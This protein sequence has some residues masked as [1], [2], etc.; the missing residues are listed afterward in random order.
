PNSSTVK[1]VIENAECWKALAYSG[2]NV[3]SS[4]D[5]LRCS[6]W[7]ELKQNNRVTRKG[8]NLS[9]Q[10]GSRK[11]REINQLQPVFITMKLFVNCGLPE[12]LKLRCSRDQGNRLGLGKKTK[13]EV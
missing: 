3:V 4:D 13:R 5:G 8:G 7:Y 10:F 2:Q 12:P 11:A 6:H 9:Q 1:A